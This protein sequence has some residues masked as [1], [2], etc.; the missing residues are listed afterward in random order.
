MRPGAAALW[1]ALVLGVFSPTIAQGQPVLKVRVRDFSDYSRVALETPQTLTFA[2]ERAG[3]TLRVKVDSRTSLRIMGEPVDSRVVKSL[4]WAKQGNTYI[5]T[6]EAKVAGFN[7]NF[8]TLSNPFQLMIDITPEAAVPSRPAAKPAPPTPAPPASPP[9]VVE[10]PAQAANLPPGA[11]GIRTIVIDPGH[12]G[13]ESGAKGRFGT[14][15]KEVTLA[16]AL[17]LKALVERNMAMRVV[18]TRDKDIDMSL[19]DRGALSNNNDAMLFISIHANGSH[20]KNSNGSEVYF[21]S[22]N[23]ADED[24]RRLA[25]LENNAGELE[26]KI[27]RQD[28]DDLQMILWDMAQSAFIKKSG[29]LAEF[30]QTELNTLVGTANR[31]IKQAPFKVLTEVACPAVLVETAFLSNPEEERKLADPAF[32]DSVAQAVYRGLLNTIRLYSQE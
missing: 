17:K 29:Q 21:L 31:G 6:I 13:L 23:A 4:N 18:L 14:L 12:G 19:A 22:L 11:K 10:A 5:L 26:Q 2:F 15:E 24:T 25:Y 27:D 1:L 3:A 28:A 32:Q 30:I 20:R 8:Y 7:Y 9:P 16:I